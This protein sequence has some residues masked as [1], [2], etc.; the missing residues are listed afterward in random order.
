MKCRPEE[1]LFTCFSTTPMYT[2][3]FKGPG[4]GETLHGQAGHI[5][6]DRLK[7]KSRPRC[8][9]RGELGRDFDRRD[10]LFR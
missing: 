4:D 2:F 7:L 8:E 9:I 10:G 1:A 3:F 5:P 6:G